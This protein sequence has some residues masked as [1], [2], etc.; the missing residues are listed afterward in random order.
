MPSPETLAAWDKAHYWHSFTQMAEY[1]PL[2]IERAEGCTLIDIHGRRLIDG[3]SSMWC[4]VHGHGHPRIN[5]AIRDQLEKIAHCTSL[6]MGNSTTVELARRLVEI[7]PT[8]LDHVFFSSDGSSAV[9]AALKMA[10]QYWR[11]CS[12]PKSE[13]TKFVALGEA[14]HGDTIG[15]VSVGGVD[16]F[17]SMF[18]PLLFDVE[19]VPAPDVTKLPEGVHAD[20]ACEYYLGLVEKLLAEKHAEIAAFVVEPLVQGAAGILIHP[21]GYLRGMRELTR[22][23][24]VLLIADEVAVGFGR[25]GTMFACEQEEVTPDLLCLGKGMTSGYLPMAAT[26]V[27]DEVY[28]AFLGS[29]DSY[30]AFLHG[31][32]FAGNPLAAAAALATLDLFTEERTLSNV[33]GRATELAAGL[34]RLSQ[35][36][37]VGAIRQQGLMVGI[38]LVQDKERNMAYPAQQRRGAAVCRR[39]MEQGVWLRPL[40]DTIVIMPPL[41]ISS[42]LLSTILYAVEYG[43]EQVTRQE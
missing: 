27:T 39:A 11:Q 16:R 30:R 14:Y 23:Y 43:I 28:G 35:H 5:Q 41:C 36:P 24:D 22:K 6:G 18:A 10:F 20:Q 38:D 31:H 15:S 42:N 21:P 40:S 3:V 33:S 7:V 13:K 17:T 8:G 26:L 37:H 9:E 25:T 32:T 12:A 1:E 4:N 19:R 2:V 29:A 34:E